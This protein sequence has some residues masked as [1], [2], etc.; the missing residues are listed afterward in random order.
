[1]DS[2]RSAS[3]PFKLFVISQVVIGLIAVAATIYASLQTYPLIQK[4]ARLESEI[5][6]YEQRIIA[7]ENQI[8]FLE[9]K[10]VDV[11]DSLNEAIKILNE[12]TTVPSKDM[13]KPQALATIVPGLKSSQSLD[14]YDFTL[15]IDAPAELK[16]QIMRVEY[17]FLTVRPFLRRFSRNGAKPCIQR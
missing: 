5:K 14:I 8:K 13:I 10:K 15:W 1:M 12:K 11:Q 6:D 4:K 17:I 2:L 16:S 9:Q 3:Q 7:Y